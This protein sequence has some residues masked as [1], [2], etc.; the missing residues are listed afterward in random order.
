MEIFERIF[1]STPD[2]LLVVDAAGCIVRANRQAEA[3]FGLGREVLVGRPVE[4]LLPERF[5]ARHCQRRAGFFAHPRNRPMGAGLEL[6]ALRQDGSE[7][8]VEIDLTPLQ[9]QQGEFVSCAIRDVTDRQQTEQA[10]RASE[11]RYRTLVDFA[12]DGILTVDAE[13]RFLDANPAACEMLGFSRG[14][15]LTLAFADV[16]AP[17]D[18]KRVCDTQARLAKGEPVRSDWT[19]RRKDGSLFPGEINAR[20]LPDA[21]Y[22]GV[23]RDTSEYQHVLAA[24]S[25]SEEVLRQFIRHAP[26]AIAMLDTDLRYLQAS[27]RWI[28]DYRLE[29]Q[30]LIGRLHYDVFPEIPQRW[31]DIHQR[32]L[33]GNVERCDED[34]FPRLDG[35]IDWLQWEARPW[36]KPDGSVGGVIFFTQVITDRKRSEAALRDSEARFRGAFDFAAIGMALVAPDGHWLRVN[37]SICD[38]VG[39]SEEEL[40]ATDFQSITHPDDLDADLEYVR[41]ML[42]GAIT[43]YHMEKRYLHKDGH[44]VPILL[45][46]SLVR[47]VNGDPIYFI[48]QIQDIT[49]RKEIERKFAEASRGREEILA[50]LDT[51]QSDAPVGL[52]FVGPDC[53]FVRCND[54]LAE[55]NGLSA[56]EHLGRTLEEVVPDLWPWLEPLYRHVLSGGDHILNHEL[57][58][59][60]AAQPGRTRY[61]L[62]NLYPVSI[63]DEILGAGVVVT[64]ITDRKQAEQELAASEARLRTVVESMPVLMNA[65]DDDRIIVAWNS[66]C[67]RVTGYTAEE[68][69]GNPRALELLYPDAAYRTEMLAAWE[70]RGQD[71]RG[72]AWEITCK[73]GSTK[74][75]EWS[76]VSAKLPIP[77]WKVWGIGIDVTERLK[78]EEQLL[79][80]QKLQAIGQLAGGVAH[81]FNNLLTIISG[82]CELLLGG[83]LEPC[84]PQR[85]AVSEIKAAAERATLLTRQLLMFSRKAV[86]ATRVLDLN[87]LVES[88]GKLLR[89]LIGEDVTFTSVLAPALDHVRVDPGQLEQVLMNLAVNARDAMPR[90]GR[91]TLETRNVFLDEEY[92]RAFPDCKPGRYAQLIVSDTGVGMTPEVQARIF[93]PFFTTKGPG[94]GTGL[95][96]STV[97][98]IV[99]QSGGFLSVFSDEGVGTTFNLFLP[100]ALSEV[101]SHGSLVQPH[102]TQVGCETILLVEDEDAVRQIARLALEDRG[103]QVFEAA[104]GI[105]ALHVFDAHGDEIDLLLT[106]VVMP[107]MSGREL[108]E[109]LRHRS[110]NLI[111][112]YMSGYNDDAVVRHGLFEGNDAF[113]QKPFTPSTLGAIVRET[114]DARR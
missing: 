107:G 4:T 103:Y 49:E 2:A 76:N 53:R 84:H 62:C 13:G 3:M 28:K 92:C 14:E 8:P 31:K 43:S 51:L 7:F 95:G 91:L 96:L 39:Y 47:D 17:E 23:L 5:R 59:E 93:E 70:E 102:R 83:M 114:L 10:L 46:V 26:A 81:D 104:S 57:V 89:R 60:T 97:Y 79:Q 71:Y 50:L 110:P 48:S 41:Q 37:Q 112:L 61:W 35:T 27:E 111:V 65:F 22:F 32:V 78:L 99:Q 80:S 109:T 74:T 69:V 82:Y 64:E 6:Q 20:R 75:I 21:R 87:D 54:A 36:R 18:A 34:P 68:M 88:T 72:W 90:G 38:I 55:M 63:Q 58:G 67:Q 24:L 113:L 105:K 29:G 33:A 66:E 101:I 11:E 9:T 85:V 44:E 30:E 106:D 16:I 98:G 52:A 15:L 108:A 77:G 25:A 73:D 45:S 100:A 40:L 56:E 1:D 19:F 12:T 86:L 42:V 94:K